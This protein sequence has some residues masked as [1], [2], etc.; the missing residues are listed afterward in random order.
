MTKSILSVAENTRP[1]PE[2]DPTELQLTSI[3]NN[4]AENPLN[5]SITLRAP[6]SPWWEFFLHFSTFGIYTGF[7][8]VARI[9]EVKLL[10][11]QPLKPWLWIFVPNAVIF[12]PFVLPALNKILVQ[13]E[14][15]NNVQYPRYYFRLWAT[16]VFT[17]SI[18]L[19][20]NSKYALPPWL[21]LVGLLL[22]SCVFCIFSQRINS[23]KNNLVNVNFKGKTSGYAIWEWLIVIPLLP[24]ALIM[25]LYLSITPYMVEEISPLPDQTTY[26]K[27]GEYQLAIHGDG[28]RNVE[29]GTF[30]DGSAENEFA[31]A[32]DGS[33]FIVFKFNDAVTLND[34]VD[35]RIDHI[36]SSFSRSQCREERSLA[37]SQLNVIAYV[38]CE[39]QHVGDPQLNTVTVFKNGDNLYELYGNL[40]APK[41]S[42]PGRA[43]EFKQMAKEFQPL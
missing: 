14:K 40:N 21:T 25:L 27:Q 3:S 11:K 22:W 36:Q 41:Y 29:I 23:I 43:A 32:V 15:D 8:F 9:K 35:S 39:G 20:I 19:W 26:S 28:W 30:T 7:W 4:G 31:G 12:Q 16:A 2:T 24:I 5:E 34:I 6:R 18:C 37:Q 17:L 1:D 33:Y 38:I 42:Y 10:S 13:I